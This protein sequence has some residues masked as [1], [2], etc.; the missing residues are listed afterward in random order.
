VLL[1]ISGTKA[2]KIE[3]L[4]GVARVVD[5]FMVFDEG[6]CNVCAASQESFVLGGEIGIFAPSRGSGC[7]GHGRH[8]EVVMGRLFVVKR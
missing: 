1:G 7:Y 8:D 2:V 5:G 3:I 4:L 6:V